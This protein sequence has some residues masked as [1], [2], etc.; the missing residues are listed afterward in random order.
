MMYIT[1]SAIDILVFYI[2]LFDTVLSFCLRGQS[3][4]QNPTCPFIQPRA[5]IDLNVMV[6]FHPF[7]NFQVALINS[8]SRYASRF[9]DN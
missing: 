9:M 4:N 1:L 3:K 8:M 6:Q 5:N 2:L 7:S